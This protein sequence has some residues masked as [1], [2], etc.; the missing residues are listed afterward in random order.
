MNG[1]ILV[2]CLAG[3][4]DEVLPEIKN[5]KGVK[6]A[7]GTLGRWDIVVKVS[8]PSL[9]E[10]DKITY[11]IKSIPGIRDVETLMAKTVG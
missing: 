8:I 11:A 7:F 1:T 10:M 2:H 3:K 6:E 4:F 9:Q 5:I